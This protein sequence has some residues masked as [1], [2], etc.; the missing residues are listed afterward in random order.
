MLAIVPPHDSQGEDIQ[1]WPG[2]NTGKFT[3]SSAYHLIIGGLVENV[4]NKWKQIW[5][6]DVI[7]RVRVFIW[8]LSQERLLTR[9]RLARWH[10]GD[11]N[12]PQFEETISH[13][14]RDCPIAVLIWNHLLSVHDRGRFFVVSFKDW[15]ILNLDNQFGHHHGRKWNAIW[16]TTCHLLWY[17]RNKRIHDDEFVN[18]DRP[19]NLV[20][21]YVDEYNQVGMLEPQD[22]NG[23]IMQQIDVCWLKP[24]LGWYVL[25]TDGAAKIGERKAGCGGTLRN[26]TDNWVDGFAKALGDTT[27]Y[28]A[29]LWGILEGLIM[30]KRR[31][32]GRLDLRVDSAVIV[33]NLQGKKQGSTMGCSLMKKIYNLLADFMEVQINHVYRE[34][35]QGADMLANLGCEAT[36]ETVTFNHPPLR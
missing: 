14:V 31:G 23:R 21:Q 26:E 4:D 7:K 18:P 28:M 35:N 24:S 5:K 2:M 27:A 9:D 22:R 25:N 6:L 20:L 34:A 19:W 17:W 13:V 10:I 11:H 15:I 29:E 8:Q 36:G 3:V 30:A 33:K 12:C 32:V 1:L 16:A